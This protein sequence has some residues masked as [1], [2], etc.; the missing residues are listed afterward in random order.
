MRACVGSDGMI[1][2]LVQ[3]FGGGHSRLK[4]APA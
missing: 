4:T 2:V 3:L 1:T